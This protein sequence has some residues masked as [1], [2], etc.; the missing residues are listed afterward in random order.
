ME[1]G[2]IVSPGTQKTG[3]PFTLMVT[4]L[5]AVG[6]L[7]VISVMTKSRGTTP[8]V[9]ACPLATSKSRNML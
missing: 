1:V 6:K 3:F 8:K 2:G 9:A 7:R 4:R 5:K